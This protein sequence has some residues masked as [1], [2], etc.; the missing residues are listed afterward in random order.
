MDRSGRVRRQSFVR[1][2]SST[3]RLLLASWAVAA[4]GWWYVRGVESELRRPLVGAPALL[5]AVDVVAV[6]DATGAPIP[7]ADVTLIGAGA[8][9]GPGV[10]RRPRRTDAL[11]RARLEVPGAT[12]ARRRVYR[13]SGLVPA[14]G[15]PELAVRDGLGLRVAAAGFEPGARSVDDAIATAGRRVVPGRRYVLEFRLRPPTGPRVGLPP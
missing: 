2:R 10:P 4:A 5:V 7:D 9:A 13:L 11:G 14:A 3:R 8:D 15:D 1:V 6:D 12:L